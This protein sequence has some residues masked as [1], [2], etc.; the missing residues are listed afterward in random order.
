MLLA[1]MCITYLTILPSG[2]PWRLLTT[3]S[4]F[5]I[6]TPGYNHLLRTIRTRL[7]TVLFCSED[8]IYCPH[9]PLLSTMRPLKEV[10]VTEVV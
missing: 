6:T 1:L 7:C 3:C 8:L 5:H 2:G 4:N 9:V 10:L